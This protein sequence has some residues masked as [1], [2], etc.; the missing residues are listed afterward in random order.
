MNGVLCFISEP[1]TTSLTGERHG[2]VEP[3]E[4]LSNLAAFYDRIFGEHIEMRAEESGAEAQKPV[5]KTF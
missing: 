3:M 4:D 1:N 2:F 5:L